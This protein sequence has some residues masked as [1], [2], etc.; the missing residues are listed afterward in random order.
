[1]NN[2]KSLADQTAEEGMNF[3]RNLSIGLRLLG[4]DCVAQDAMKVLSICDIIREKDGNPTINEMAD[5]IE[6]AKDTYQKIEENYY[7]SINK[8]NTVNKE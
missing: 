3:C 4:I 1:M 7:S 8:E 5:A 6:L 2:Q